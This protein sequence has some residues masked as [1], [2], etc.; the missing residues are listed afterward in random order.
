LD[1]QPHLTARERALS[2]EYAA[3]EDVDR[4]LSD[5]RRRNLGALHVDIAHRVVNPRVFAAMDAIS[6][7]MLMKLSDTP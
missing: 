1:G 6:V 3:N 2:Q 5:D 7:G 4:A